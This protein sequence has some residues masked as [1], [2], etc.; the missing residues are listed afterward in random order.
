MNELAEKQNF[1]VLY[2]EMNV[3]A[4]PGR[5]W[6]W[7]FDY[8]QR[9]GIGEPAVIK[10]MVDLVKLH[11]SIDP[12]KVYIAGLSAGG[13]MSIIMGATYPDVFSGVGVVAGVEYSAAE[14]PAIGLSVMA[15]GASD[16]RSGVNKALYEMGKFKR[17]IPVIIIHGSMDSVVNPVNADH[18]AIQWAQINRLSEAQALEQYHMIKPDRVKKGLINGRKYSRHF[19]HDAAHRPVIEKWI[20]EGLHHAW[21]GGNPEG[22]HTDPLGPNATGIIWKFFNCYS[23]AN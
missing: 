18:V 14:N 6:N 7:F 9:R 15:H 2:P 1:I 22:S 11:Y 16:P 3:L 20:V 23:L 12:K 8:N 4:N 19:Y 13:S 21:P 10:G 17:T 5:C